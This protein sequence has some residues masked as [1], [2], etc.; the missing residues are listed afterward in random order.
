VLPQT[1]GYARSWM[2]NFVGTV[3][4]QF[5]Q[6]LALS[7]T[8]SLLGALKPMGS[9]QVLSEILVAIAMMFVVFKAP[10]LLAHHDSGGWV[11]GFLGYA[12]IRSV[13]SRMGEGGRFARQKARE[14]SY[15]QQHGQEQAVQAYTWRHEARA[16]FEHGESGS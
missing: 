1:Q 13:M 15:R 3:F 11:G 2:R 8:V 4:S 7:L 16:R 12:A 10:A 5:L 6:V 9:D 14:Q